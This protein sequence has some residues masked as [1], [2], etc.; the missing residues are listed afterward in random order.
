[1]KKLSLVIL[2]FLLTGCSRPATPEE[3]KS[4]L[5]KCDQIGWN[6]AFHK[7]RGGFGMANTPKIIKKSHLRKWLKECEKKRKSKED[8][9]SEENIIKRQQEIFQ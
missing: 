7:K 1:M 4:A 6:I 9:N 2:C 8:P 5:N 3:I